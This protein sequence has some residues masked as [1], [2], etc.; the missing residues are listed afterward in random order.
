MYTYEKKQYKIALSINVY[1][2]DI[3]IYPVFSCVYC[4]L[5]ACM[6]LVLLGILVG[7][8]LSVIFHIYKLCLGLHDIHVSAYSLL[9]VLDLLTVYSMSPMWANLGCYRVINALMFLSTLGRLWLLV[10]F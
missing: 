8:S 7:M 2:L 5:I 1:W 3:L 10:V 6:G 4:F 9:I